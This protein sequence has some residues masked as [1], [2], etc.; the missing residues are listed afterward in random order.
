M[1]KHNWIRDDIVI[2]FPIPKFAQE[3]IA[4]LEEYDA[5]EDYAYVGW[6]D[7]LDVGLKEAVRR[8]EITERQWDILSAKY[9]EVV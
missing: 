1:Q 2:D 9:V 4:D 7:A 6:A 3:I 5:N 8:G